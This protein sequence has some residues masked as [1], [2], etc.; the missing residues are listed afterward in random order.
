[1][2]AAVRNSLFD[3]PCTPAYSDFSRYGSVQRNAKL[4]LEEEEKFFRNSYKSKNIFLETDN[5]KNFFESADLT[6]TLDNDETERCEGLIT[7]K[8]C[9]DALNKFQ[10][11]KTPGSEGLTIEFYRD[12][13]GSCLVDSFNYA[14][15]YGHLSISQRL[16]IISLIPKKNKSLEYLLNWKPVSLLNNDYKIAT[17]AIAIRIS[18]TG[19]VKPNRLRQAKQATSSQ[20]GHVKPNRPRQAKQ[21]TSSQTGYVKSNRLRQAKQ[22]TSKGDISEKVLELL[23]ISCPSQ[24][25]KIYPG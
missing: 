11:N 21:A 14:Y 4:I 20:T 10:D 24:R 18:Q 25:R 2:Q 15:E 1:M 3:I 13:S 9:A 6:K 22:A 8:E 17:K 5:S 7:K 19:Y 12:A 23:R 16:G